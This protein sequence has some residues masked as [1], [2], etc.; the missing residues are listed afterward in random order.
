MTERDFCY[1]LNGF[2]ELHGLAPDPEQWAM[3]KE[4]LALVFTKVT[5]NGDK[6]LSP[7]QTEQPSPFAPYVPAQPLTDWSPYQPV[8]CAATPMPGEETTTGT[9]GDFIRHNATVGGCACVGACS[10]LPALR[11]SEVPPRV[12]HVDNKPLSKPAQSG[13]IP[14]WKMNKTVC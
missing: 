7:P 9:P 8:Y 6:P 13:G 3:I 12:D 11:L 5:G 10:C 2:A 4:H 14:F 1:W